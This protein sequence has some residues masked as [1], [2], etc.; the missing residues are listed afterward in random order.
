MPQNKL[1]LLTLLLSSLILTAC[2][3][4]AGF[5][6]GSILTVSIL[7]VLAL[8]L[9]IFA[10]IDLIRRPMDMT[11]KIIWGVVIWVLPFIGAIAYL[12]MGR[13]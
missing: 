7:G 11:T 5:V 1:A 12:I 3:S 4:L 6:G 2:D 10:I 13:N 8:V 9:I